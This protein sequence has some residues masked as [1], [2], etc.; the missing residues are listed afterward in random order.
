MTD[1]AIAMAAIEQM[2]GVDLRVEMS[3]AGVL[4][5]AGLTVVMVA[6]RKVPV[7][8]GRS[9]SVSRRVRYPNEMSKTLEGCL[10][11]LTYEI[12][13]DCSSFWTQAPLPA[14]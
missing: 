12:D 2:H 11:K 1:V 4:G 8:G 5:E 6:S 10:L 13:R 9:S 7:D 14:A 3:R